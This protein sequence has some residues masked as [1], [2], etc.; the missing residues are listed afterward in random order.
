VDKDTG[1]DWLM[2]AYA[3]AELTE[4]AAA[5]AAVAVGLTWAGAAALALLVLTVYLRRRMVYRT[6]SRRW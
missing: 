6:G 4:T 5:V 2:L 3:I 1:R